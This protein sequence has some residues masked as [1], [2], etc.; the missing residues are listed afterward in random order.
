MIEKDEREAKIIKYASTVKKIA[1][2]IAMRIPSSVSFDELISAGCLGLISAVDKFDSTRNVDFKTY[3][4]YRIKGAIL[5]EL[6]SKDLY[7]RT[8][9]KKIHQ[10]GKAIEAVEI[11]KKRPAKDEEISKELNI[12]LEDYYNIL[13]DIYKIRLLSLDKYIKN[14]DNDSSSNCSFQ[15]RM[16]SKDNPSDNVM[17]HELKK[18][19]AKAIM[20]LSNNE[21]MVISLYY[22][23]EL[24]L[25]EIGKVL[26]LTESR[27]CQIHTLS[28]VKL[29][30]KL[31]KY[32]NE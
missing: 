2:K 6:R 28:V 3:A 30:S 15:E 8:M 7:S 22:Y 24:T 4:S 17:K 18:V 12:E 27:I 25:K 14:D 21:R 9:R 5:D 16:V 1:R 11:R 13:N 23:D 10:I 19:I 20:S 32:I 31:N 29:K 26:S